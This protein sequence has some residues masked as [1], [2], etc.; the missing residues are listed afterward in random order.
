MA[1]NPALGFGSG[2]IT[3]RFTIAIS[4]NSEINRSI[5][6]R[7]AYTA[8]AA[9]RCGKAISVPAVLSTALTLNRVVELTRHKASGYLL[10]TKPT[11]TSGGNLSKTHRRW[12]L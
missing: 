1:F 2:D 6:S 10:E 5:S 12:I 9:S 3:L 11:G 8:A 4:P 7:S